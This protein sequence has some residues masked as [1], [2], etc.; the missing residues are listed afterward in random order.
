MAKAVTPTIFV[1]LAAA[2]LDALEAQ[3]D[4]MSGS[5]VGY[6][7]RLDY[8]REFDHFENHLHQMLLG[9]HFPQ[10]IATCRRTEAGGQFEGGVDQQVALLQAAVRAGCQW[11]D[12]EVE[13]VNRAG[14]S[15]L[16]QFKPA[17]VIVSYHNY[18]KTPLLGPMTAGWRA[19]RS[20]W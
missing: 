13:S 15:V 5:P 19:C 20:R 17:K 2:N 1:S 11:V 3:A 4:R 18:H 14:T 6:E 16:R 12:L 8:L 10:T 9:L 7:L